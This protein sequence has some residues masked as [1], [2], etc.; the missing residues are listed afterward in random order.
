MTDTATM[1][2]DPAGEPL[3][4]LVWPV[5]LAVF[6]AALALYGLT[7]NRGAQWQDSGEISLRIYRGELLNPRG[8]ALTHPLHFWAG[9]LAIRA[10]GLEPVFAITLVSA[11]AGALA[12]ANVF[13]ASLGLTRSLPGA[14]FAAGSLAVANTCWHLSTITEVY[15]LAAALLAAECWCL[16]VFARCGCRKAMWGMLLFNGLG[17]A[18]HLQAALTSPILAAVVVHGLA[19]RRVRVRPVLIG[20][21]LWLVGSLPYSALVMAELFRSGDLAATLR[22]ALVGERFGANVLNVSVSGRLLAVSAAFVALNF[23]NLLL[24]AAAYGLGRAGRSGLPPAGR[25]ALTAAL[26]V[27]ALFVMRYNVPDQYTFFLPVYVLLSFFGALG[28]AGVLRAAPRA[29]RAL[30]ISGLLLLGATPGVYWL[31]AKTARAAGWLDARPRKPYRDDYTYLLIP[32][33][34]VDR[35]AEIMS[36]EAVDLAGEDG[37]IIVEDGMARFAVEYRAARE[38]LPKI[39][40]RTWPG[41]DRPRARAELLLRAAATFEAD[42]PVVLVPLDVEAPAVPSPLPEQAQWAREGDLY[43]LDLIADSLESP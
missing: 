11:L 33:S 15:T 13:G 17:L 34:R 38:N 24:P 31:A 27:H 37:L 1:S 5:W 9:R 25:W 29:R 28:A 21:A 18:N 26:A 4:R 14:L 8:L 41:P 35:S 42:S 19:T 39:D 12:I 23:P 16:I 6:A 3:R 22:S 40:V 2:M 20:A 36:R 10:T 7:A 32:W 43:V 30:V